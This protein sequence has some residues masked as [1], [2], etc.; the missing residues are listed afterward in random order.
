M[1]WIHLSWQLMVIVLLVLANGFFVATEFAIV[2]VRASQLRPML[3]GGGWRVRQS[4]HVISHLD[5]YLSATQLGITLASLGLGWLGEP[6]LAH[7]IERPLA[8]LGVQS[9][10][11]VR[12][13]SYVLAFSIITFMH[14]VIGELAPKSLAIRYPRRIT[15]W[16]SPPLTIFYYLFLPAI[17]LLNG[18]ANLL[19]RWVGIPPATETE[20]R[21]THEELQYV[22]MHARHVHPSDQLINRL[23]LKALRLR[24]T[25]A[26]EIMIPKDRV[27]VLWAS[28]PLAQNLKIAEQAGYSRLPVCGDRLEEVL[29]IVHVK[30]L[31]W[32]VVSL[33]PEQARL[34]DIMRP[35]LT[36]TPETRL[37]AMLQLFQKSRSHLAVVI[38]AQNQMQGIVSFEDVLEELV[39][40]IRDEFDI[41]KGPIFDRTEDS[42]LVDADMPIRDVA[43]EMNWPL[44]RHTT[45]TVEKWCLSKWGRMPKAGEELRVENYLI[46]AE[47]VTPRGLRRVR[48]RR[49]SADQT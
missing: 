13:T 49:L 3:P 43:N 44:P 38:D 15:L 25:T 21:F 27:S 30:E 22:L 5:A 10:T 6:Y 45:M 28:A 4:L 36:F 42:I 19:L 48:F 46:T 1:E 14:I 47:E 8:A 18:T 23:L 20:H 41:E 33:G 2:K 34:T 17:W 12:T 11:T 35:V 39:G 37:P 9:E 31:L 29:G 26:A 40:D 16:S 24:E 32:Q 7:W